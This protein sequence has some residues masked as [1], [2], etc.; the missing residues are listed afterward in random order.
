MAD[1]PTPS[2]PLP[3]WLTAAV[4]DRTEQVVVVCL[5]LLMVRRLL[6]SENHQAWLALIAETSVLVFVLFR[7]STSTISPRLGDWLLAITA[8]SAPLMIQPV[9]R[10]AALDMFVPL[11]IGGIYLGNLI[12]IGGKL[13]LRRSFGIAPA[14]RGIKTD[15]L[16]RL[17]RHPIYAGYLVVHLGTLLLMP[18]LFNLVIYGIGWWAQ[19]LRLLAEE[20][21]L[22]EDP[23]YYAFMEKTRWRLL[24]GLF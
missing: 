24:P 12:Q 22:S 1:H 19:I 10:P 13:F 18:S 2:P 7:H 4:L 16:Y 9:M 3:R 6:G 20:R 23:A 8:T 21:L 11:A 5:W 14:N 17:V 15:G